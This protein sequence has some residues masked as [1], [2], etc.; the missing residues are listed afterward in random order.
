MSH[1]DAVR[2]WPCLFS[3]ELPP[4]EEESVGVDSRQ[5]R[6]GRIEEERRTVALPAEFDATEGEAL[7]RTGRE[8]RRDS[9][10]VVGE[11]VTGER[12]RARIRQAANRSPAR[13][14]RDTSAGRL[15]G[16]DGAR[17]RR[18]C[19]GRRRGGG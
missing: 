9:H 10:L 13:R 12:T 1:L 15:C 5:S 7:G 18:A 16:R 14:H 17:V 8:A 4:I 11:A 3:N 6:G 19:G 2:A